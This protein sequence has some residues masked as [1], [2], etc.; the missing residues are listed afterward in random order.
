[1]VGSMAIDLSKA[2]DSLPHGLLIAKIQA[3]GVSLSPCELIASYLHNRKQRVKICDQRT[4]WLDVE[5]GVPQGS[6]LGPLLFNTL[7]NDIFFFSEKCSLFSYADD[8]V[9]SCAGSSVEEI[10]HVLSHEINNLLDWF[11]ANSLAVNPSKFQAML[12]SNVY[13]STSEA[14]LGL[15][16]NDT[17]VNSTDSITILGV[18][19]DNKLNFNDHIYTLCPKTG[20]KVN[21][22]QRLSKSLDKY[23][24]LAIYKRFIMSNFNFCPVVWM[25]TSK[26]S[27]NRLEDI[28][29]RALRFVLSDYD[30]Y[31][32]NLLTAPHGSPRSFQI[33]QS[34]TISAH[35]GSRSGKTSYT[36]RI[37]WQ[38]CSVTISEDISTT[39]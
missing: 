34:L 16:I 39:K 23:S 1:M 30:S 24:K 7:I 12:L 10:H 37:L 2:F 15:V 19:V 28:Q 27:L 35:T 22:L 6:I 26:S 4:N 18:I 33:A 21:A 36:E 17:Q 29:R 14:E 32:E 5:R 8:N 9:I 25:F 11:N 3:Y 20:K 13:T 31:Y 38:Q